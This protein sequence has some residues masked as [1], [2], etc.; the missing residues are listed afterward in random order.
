[1]SAG[2]EID[3]EKEVS[4]TDAQETAMLE[5][6]STLTAPFDLANT[7]TANSTHPLFVLLG[8][9]FYQEVN[10]IK[11]SLKNDAFNALAIVKVEGV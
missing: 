10:G 2:T 1:M 9:Q 11:Y 6:N 5:L 3:F 8:I 7:V 4:V